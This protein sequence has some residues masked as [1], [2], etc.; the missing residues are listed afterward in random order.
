ML[1]PFSY[2]ARLALDAD[3]PPFGF[4]NSNCLE[5]DLVY[6]D[7][8]PLLCCPANKV[9]G[10]AGDQSSAWVLQL[11][12]VFSQLVGLSCDVYEGKLSALF[13]EIV[14]SN[15]EKASGSRLRVGKKGT[16]EL[17][18]SALL[19]MMRIVEVLLVVGTRRGIKEVYYEALFDFVERSWA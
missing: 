7:P 1:S 13:E 10:K 9:R 6:E 16:R 17:N 2:S 12:K 15:S 8:S 4:P 5:L 18:S 3:C 14:A 19:T 11:V